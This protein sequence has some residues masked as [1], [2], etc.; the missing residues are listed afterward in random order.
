[1]SA[2]GFLYFF[3]LYNFENAAN[4]FMSRTPQEV[5]FS[6]LTRASVLNITCTTL[7]TGERIIVQVEQWLTV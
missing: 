7:A 5:R 1:M 3:Y 4:Y 6:I 2:R